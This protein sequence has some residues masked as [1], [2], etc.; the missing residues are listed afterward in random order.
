MEF[1]SKKCKNCGHKF[2]VVQFNQK[3]CFNPECLSVWVHSERQKE[4]K[5]RKAKL[6]KELLTVQDW[7][8]IAQQTFNK[9][10]NARDYGLPCISCQ[11]PITGRVN[12]SHYFNANNHWNVRFDP[13]N[14]HSSCVQ[15]NQFLSGNLNEYR[16]HLI[17][18][19]GQK[20]FDEL[21]E[22]AKKTRKFTIDELK[23]ITE[24]HKILLKSF[25][26]KK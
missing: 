22:R 9:W 21:E 5:K 19:I 18:K 15:C 6:K 10:I 14:V 4:W 16:R 17:T 7:I 23:K 26:D 13:E 3:F 2:Q 12:A 11:K 1:K 20:Q 24:A 25:A 8:K